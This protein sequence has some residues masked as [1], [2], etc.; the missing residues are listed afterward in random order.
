MEAFEKRKAAHSVSSYLD[1]CMDRGA[2]LIVFLFPI[3]NLV[4]PKAGALLIVG[5]TLMAV[6]FWMKERHLAKTAE[7]ILL[8]GYII[9]LIVAI[10]SILNTESYQAALQE[11]RIYIRVLAVVPIA[12]ILS[13]HIGRFWN[14]FVYGSVV[15]SVILLIYA[16][17]QILIDGQSHA[18][19]AYQRIEYGDFSLLLAGILMIRAIEYK[20]MDATKNLIYI[21][22]FSGL[23]AG[24]LSG[25]RGVVLVIPITLVI[26]YFL[27]LRNAEVE[28]RTEKN[29][30]FGVI[31]AIT[32]I[33]MLLTV[34]VI[35]ERFQHA[36]MEIESYLVSNYQSSSIG[37]RLNMWRDSVTIFVESPIIGTG[38][39]D[40]KTDTAALIKSGGSRATWTF[41][42]AHSIYFHNLATMG[43]LGLLASVI[44]I[45]L[46]PWILFSYFGKNLTYPNI[47]MAIYSG[48]YSIIIL[49][50]YG[51]RVDW[52]LSS[53]IVDTYI[54]IIAFSLAGIV[55]MNR[56]VLIQS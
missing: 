55:I 34:N 12:L 2:G 32:I 19:G 47:K 43:L 33:A 17:Y 27:T 20:G 9:F 39:G 25:S 26:I 51:L 52:L 37:D 38:I 22:I 13:R 40:F 10:S 44:S 56:K 42:N 46:I 29:K 30:V 41:T 54:L 8:S 35:I 18:S 21:G 1:N 6:L 16:V 50:V 14:N 53:V 23:I 15:G 5:I 36:N 45:L 48:K 4:V 24:I 7:L 31:I 3:V 28:N 49:S 11:I